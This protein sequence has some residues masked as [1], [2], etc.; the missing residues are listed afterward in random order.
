MCKHLPRQKRLPRTFVVRRS[1][2]PT[3]TPSKPESSGGGADLNEQASYVSW[4]RRVSGDGRSE[5]F[6][7]SDV[8]VRRYY[9]STGVP[10][11][12]ASSSNPNMHFKASKHQ[13]LFNPDI[14]GCAFAVYCLYKYGKAVF[15]LSS[16]SASIHL[17]GDYG[18]FGSGRLKFSPP[19]PLQTHRTLRGNKAFFF[20]FR[21]DKE[22]RGRATTWE[23]P[24]LVMPNSKPS[25]C[26]SRL[27]AWR[28]TVAGN[29]P[30]QKPPGNAVTRSSSRRWNWSDPQSWQGGEG[31][32]VNT[33]YLFSVALMCK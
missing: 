6:G 19:S 18:N 10:Q 1:R 9:I 32:K 22:A 29:D 33:E 28:L 11:P 23:G 7:V 21:A 8:L 26:T 31:G 2:R 24:Q 3:S 25:S 12:S 4:S 27:S 5:A 14:F 13:L 16:D 17:D 20:L 15:K 30:E